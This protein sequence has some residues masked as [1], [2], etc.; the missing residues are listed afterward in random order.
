MQIGQELA[1]HLPSVPLSELLIDVDQATGFTN[2]LTH[3]GGAQPRHPALEHRRN[4]YTAIFAQARN[5]GIGRMAELCGTS[6]DTITWTTRWYLREEPR[7]GKT[8]TGQG[9]GQ[10][11]SGADRRCGPPPGRMGPQEDEY[12]HRNRD[13]GDERHESLLPRARVATAPE[14]SSK[15]PTPTSTGPTRPR[16]DAR[17]FDRTCS[18]AHR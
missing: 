3:A 7:Q 12:H 2:H 6:P 8:G 11:H 14:T 4:L 17:A 1:A 15:E 13:Q 10:P 5:F 18:P 9:V 16:A